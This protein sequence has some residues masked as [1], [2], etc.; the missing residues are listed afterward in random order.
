MLF[1]YLTGNAISNLQAGLILSQF[2]GLLM[3]FMV[4]MVGDEMGEGGARYLFAAIGVAR[5]LIPIFMGYVK[6]GIIL[7]ISLGLVIALSG[8]KLFET[9]VA[10]SVEGLGFIGYFFITGLV[11]VAVLLHLLSP[12]ARADLN[13]Q[14]A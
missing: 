11:E 7:K 13:N 3:V 1:K 2:G 10:V 14:Q 6:R 9:V 4:F 5:M 12:K 8:L